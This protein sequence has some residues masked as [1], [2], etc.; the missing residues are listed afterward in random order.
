MPTAWHAAACRRRRPSTPG[1][2][3]PARPPGSAGRP[4]L[5]RH[6]LGHAAW[7]LA[8]TTLPS[9]ICA[10]AASPVRRESRWTRSIASARPDSG[11]IRIT[12]PWKRAR[13]LAG[14]NRF[15]IRSEPLDRQLRL[16]ADHGVD[17]PG[18]AEVGEVR[19]PAAGCAR[20]RS[21][22]GSACRRPPRRARPGTSPWPA[23]PTSP[24]R[25][26]RPRSGRSRCGPQELLVGLRERAVDRGH[27]GAALEV[28]H[29]HLVGA[30]LHDRP[31]RASPR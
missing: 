23:S 22:R 21:G 30:R 19:R 24:R 3:P 4:P 27:E 10:T 29:A 18:Q 6:A 20:R 13:P 31:R 11:S 5:E 2:R 8:A 14:S 15:G 1:P 16:D 26:C 28:Q 7:T 17:G 25:A 9:R 12:A